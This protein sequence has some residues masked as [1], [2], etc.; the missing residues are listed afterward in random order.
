MSSASRP[1]ASCWVGP[2]RSSCAPGSSRSARTAVHFPAPRC[3]PWRSRTTAGTATGS[4]CSTG[5]KPGDRVLLVD[6]WAERGS[7]S[8]AAADLVA[9]C[10][11]TQLGLSVIVD[12]LS[13]NVRQTL[14]RVTAVVRAG[15]LGTPS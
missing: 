13:D 12:E 1:A 7:Q 15:Q 11:A 9:Q 4:G 14:P 3:Q 6:D 2:A 8:R 5:S 10:G